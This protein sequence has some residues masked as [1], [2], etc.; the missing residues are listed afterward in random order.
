M[1]SKANL[2]SK[3]MVKYWLELVGVIVGAAGGLLY[4]K[5]VGCSNGTCPITSS[6]VLSALFGALLGFLIFS[7]FKKGKSTD[8]K[9]NN[10][11]TEKAM[12]T[13]E[14][15]KSDFLTKVADFETNPQTWKYL[16][17]KPA[18]VDFYATWCGPCKSI[19]PVLED[20][21]AEYEGKIHVYKIDVDKEQNLASAFNVRSIPTL[22][23]IPVDGKPQM[24]QGAMSKSDFKKLIDEFLLKEGK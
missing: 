22:L 6:P 4:W 20:L 10:I 13:V 3:M 19:A 18:I 11:K 17:D 23:F 15:T 2:A 24:A 7:M 14:L 16:G 1:K 8:N 5:Y 21:A 12:K 9:S